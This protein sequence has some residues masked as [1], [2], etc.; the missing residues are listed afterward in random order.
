MLGRTQRLPRLDRRQCRLWQASY[1]GHG[2][3]GQQGTVAASARR[4]TSSARPDAEPP[5]CSHNAGG[6]GQGFSLARVT[7]QGRVH[8]HVPAHSMLPEV[9]DRLYVV[10]GIQRLGGISQAEP[11]IVTK[12]WSPFGAHFLEAPNGMHQLAQEE[13]AQ[14]Q[15]LK[16]RTVR[17]T[18]ADP[19]TSRCAHADTAD[20]H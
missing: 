7:D 10:S 9:H 8:V 19:S 16:L 11:Q 14:T 2:R 20:G 5:S 4:S 12:R 3:S 17:A 1:D 13:R 6:A 18:G 15:S